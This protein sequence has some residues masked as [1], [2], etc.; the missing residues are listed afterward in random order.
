MPIHPYIFKYIKK[1]YE[2]TERFLFTYNNE[3]MSDKVYRNNYFKPIMEQLGIKR[4]VA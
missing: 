4:N 1:R 2:N 3:R